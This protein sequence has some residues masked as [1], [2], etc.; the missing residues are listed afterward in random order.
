MRFH[1][2]SLW[3]KLWNDCQSLA[4]QGIFPKENS[5]NFM[6]S[7]H[8]FARRWIHPNR[9]PLPLPLR[10]RCVAKTEKIC[11][12]WKNGFCWKYRERGI[13]AVVLRSEPNLDTVGSLWQP[14]Q[15]CHVDV[16]LQQIAFS[17]CC[18]GAKLKWWL[19]SECPWFRCCHF[20]WSAHGHYITCG[21]NSNSPW[22]SC[23][24]VTGC[25]Y[26]G[27]LKWRLNSDSTRCS[28]PCIWR[29]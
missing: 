19:N 27:K 13:V 4:T 21:F 11:E 22:F 18:C 29:R 5:T 1:A 9:K 23:P 3:V 10:P 24:C 26:G 14:W 15:S 12:W 25:R 6:A 2:I 7:W 8:C 20:R 28:C 16:F 17:G